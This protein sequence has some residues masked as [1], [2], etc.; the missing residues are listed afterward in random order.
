MKRAATTAVIAVVFWPL[1]IIQIAS[2]QNYRAT[3]LDHPDG[4]FTAYDIND[5][6]QIAGTVEIAPNTS[7]AVRREPDGQF[8]DLPGLG[9]NLSRPFGINDLGHLCGFANDETGGSHAVVWGKRRPF[10]NWPCRQGGPFP[11]RLIST[12]RAL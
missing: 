5:A 4:P 12:T 7:L 3:L 9:G 8:T 10:A 1:V 6:G 11:L 2:A